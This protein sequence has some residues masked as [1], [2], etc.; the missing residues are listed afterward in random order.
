MGAL[1]Q[2]RGLFESSF[3]GGSKFRIA[4]FDHIAGSRRSHY[5]DGK[6]HKRSAGTIT[7]R[8]PKRV[9]YD[10]GN[11]GGRVR[12]RTVLCDRPAQGHRV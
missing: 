12:L 11:R 2:S 5:V 6:A 8:R 10:L 3:V 7:F 1:D 9:L 4:R